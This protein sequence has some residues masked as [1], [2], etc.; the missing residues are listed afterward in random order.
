MHCVVHCVVNASRM[1][2][3]SSADRHTRVQAEEEE[4]MAANKH[5]LGTQADLEKQVCS[6]VAPPLTMPCFAC[7]LPCR[8]CCSHLA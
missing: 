8:A 1:V 2:P 5:R 3:S 6:K 4:L 7:L